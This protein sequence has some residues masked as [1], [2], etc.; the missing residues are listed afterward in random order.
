MARSLELWR[1]SRC[2]GI[3]DSR[4]SYN[5]YDFNYTLSQGFVILVVRLQLLFCCKRTN[6]LPDEKSSYTYLNRFQELHEDSCDTLDIR[7]RRQLTSSCRDLCK[8]DCVGQPM[9]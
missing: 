9:G 8:P 7:K 1:G 5:L 4:V 6:T 3:C 2:F